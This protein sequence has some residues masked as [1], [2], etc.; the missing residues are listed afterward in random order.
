MTQLALDVTTVGKLA[1][2]LPTPPLLTSQQANWNHVF[3]ADYQH[4]GAELNEPAIPFHVLEVMDNR[5]R[6]P[7]ERR[8]GTKFLSY[9]IRQG[10][11]FLCPAQTAQWITWKKTLNFS[12][13]VFDPRFIEQLANEVDISQ[14]IEFIPQWQVFDP[15]IQ[16]IT[17]ALKADLAA[18]CPAGSLYGQHF[19][20][21][22]ATHLL[23]KLTVNQPNVSEYDDGLPRH[24]L[25]KVLE[26]I[27]A[28]LTEKIQLEDLAKISGMSVFY[29]ARQF[30]QSMQ[31]QPHQ[32]VLRR[33]VER[34]KQLLKCP[35]YSVTKVAAECGFA[36][37]S[38]LSRHFYKLVK[39]SPGEFRNQ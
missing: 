8:L 5:S 6:V 2:S 37:P 36:N 11:V 24:Q 29:F 30:K 12:L 21:A 10:E 34:A 14:A 38:H 35:D 33:R 22:L 15:V 31:I 7:H 27:E 1:E 25:K 19:G 32:Y 16:T 23:T 4:P 20:T 26:H 13:V 28:N 18:G 17:N 39:M 9:P 3:L